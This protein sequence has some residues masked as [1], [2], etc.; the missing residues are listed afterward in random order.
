[1]L[2]LV[3]AVLTVGI[4]L[5]VLLKN[6][7][8]G[9]S[10]IK[11]FVFVGMTM[12]LVVAGIMWMF[13]YDPKAGILNALLRWIGAGSLARGWLGDPNT[14]LAALI[15]VSV[16][17][18]SGF[19]S[20]AFVAGLESIPQ[21]MQEQAIVDG[22]NS[23]QAFWRVTFPLLM[24]VTVVVIVMTTIWG[25]KMFDIVYVTTEGGPGYATEVMAHQMYY[26]AFRHG[27]FG[28]GSAI[29]V[30]LTLLALLISS[31]VVRKSTL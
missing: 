26:E 25:L 27:R 30:I 14:A 3:P 6:R 9:K 18:W 19:S 7:V 8:L 1:M 13:I 28:Q 16:W 2:V 24:P 29:A 5:A 23:W 10:I 15:V 20:A 21:E 22:C 4:S 11:T 17:I 31:L 12:P